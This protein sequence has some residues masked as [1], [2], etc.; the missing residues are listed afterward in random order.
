LQSFQSLWVL[1]HE[2]GQKIRLASNPGG[3]FKRDQ[4]QS[5]SAVPIGGAAMNHT[6]LSL[7]DRI[8]LALQ[9]APHLAGRKLRS[10][11]RDGHVVLHGSVNSFF[12]KQMAQEVVR[13]IDGVQ[14]IA[15]ELMVIRDDVRRPHAIGF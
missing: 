5:V 10:H 2:E 1:T 9:T 8:N 12:E 6:V 11:T 15:N 14:R 4:I 13:R 3:Y 7:D